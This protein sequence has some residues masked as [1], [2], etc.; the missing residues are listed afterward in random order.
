MDT[1]RGTIQGQRNVNLTGVCTPY[2][3][4]YSRPIPRQEA[5]LNPRLQEL[6]VV[7]T[8][9]QSVKGTTKEKATPGERY[10]VSGA[11]LRLFVL[12]PPDEL[13]KFDDMSFQRQ[14]HFARQRKSL[15]TGIESKIQDG[16]QD[17]ISGIQS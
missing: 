4:A 10:L 15:S 9:D 1:G 13:K 7:E 5:G 6:F 17:P 14:L 11:R 8:E 2:P 3:A 12:S 16:V